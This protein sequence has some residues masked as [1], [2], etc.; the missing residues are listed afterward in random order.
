[1]TLPFSATS[2]EP[3]N[4]FF[5]LYAL[6]SASICSACVAASDVEA[7]RKSAKTRRAGLDM[8]EILWRARD[9]ERHVI[10]RWLIAVPVARGV[11]Q[12][13]DDRIRIHALRCGDK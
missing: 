10:V 13:F 9:H 1:M 8:V 2:A 7:V 4:C 3:L 5:A 12:R 11:L 6:R